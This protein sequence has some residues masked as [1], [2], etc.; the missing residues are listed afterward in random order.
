MARLDMAKVDE[1]RVFCL[2]FV[3]DFPSRLQGRGRTPT[4]IGFG[5]G[6]LH[7]PC[8]SNIQIHY[9]CWSNKKSCGVP[10]HKTLFKVVLWV[11]RTGCTPPP[12]SSG[13]VLNTS[14]PPKHSCALICVLS[15]VRNGVVFTMPGK[16]CSLSKGL[17]QCML[18]SIKS[19]L[20]G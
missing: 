20:C 1:S 15:R 10:W 18:L 13:C 6:L 12:M 4:P 19:F 5:G 17:R 8:A 11:S 7:P 9:T 16:T 2:C 3:A 14:S